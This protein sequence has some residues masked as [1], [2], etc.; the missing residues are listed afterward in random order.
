MLSNKY[1][2]PLKTVADKLDVSDLEWALFGSANLAF[3]GLKIN[4]RDMDICVHESKIWQ[5]EEMFLSY[6][7]SPIKKV[8]SLFPDGGQVYKFVV[9]IGDIPI[10]FNAEFS[11]TPYYYLQIEK[12]NID[13]I[14]YL[15]T[16]I[17]SIPLE[18]EAK[19]Y[20][21]MGREKKAEMIEDFLSKGV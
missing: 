21:L 8:D 20:R 14:Y 11:Q 12:G 17:N 4:P 16:L 7:H 2:W 13:K 19:Y 18:V 3:R 10:E 9:N 6:P 15:G 1:F 5:I